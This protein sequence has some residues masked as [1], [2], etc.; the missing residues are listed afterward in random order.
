MPQDFGL[1]CICKPGLSF[2]FS[3]LKASIGDLGFPASFDPKES[4]YT[5]PC[6]WKSFHYPKEHL[7]IALSTDPIPPPHIS[8]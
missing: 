8:V 4:C 2:L 1:A 7:E 3:L 5:P 6:V